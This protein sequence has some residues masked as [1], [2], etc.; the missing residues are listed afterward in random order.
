MLENPYVKEVND[1]K[2]ITKKKED[3]NI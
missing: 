2:K 1:M 3:M